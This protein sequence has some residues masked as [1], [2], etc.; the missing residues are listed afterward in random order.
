MTNDTAEMTLHILYISICMIR[1][2]GILITTSH[3]L[4]ENT[5]TSV[6]TGTNRPYRT[7]GTGSRNSWYRPA[8]T[9]GQSSQILTITI[10][11]K[12]LLLCLLLFDNIG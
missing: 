8:L 4:P 5:G 7:G 6:N 12:H 10:P 9:L 2:T 1:N 11:L 3:F